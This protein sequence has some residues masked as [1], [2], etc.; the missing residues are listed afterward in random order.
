TGDV[1]TP[2]TVKKGERVQFVQKKT[3]R[4]TLTTIEVPYKDFAKDVKSAKTI[5]LD[6]GEMEFHLESIH[7]GVVTATAK[8]SGAVGSRRHVNLPGAT[9]SLPSFTKKDWEDI[10]FG[11]R[12]QAD[13]FAP[14]FIRSGKDVLELRKFLDKNKSGA[15]IIAKIETAQAVDAIDEIIALSDG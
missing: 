1:T 14:S 10:T 4:E 11:I 6:N 15:L 5:L 9:I 8:D 3:G 2:I 13:F 7:G 12:H